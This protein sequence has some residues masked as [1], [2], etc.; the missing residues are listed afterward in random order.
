MIAVND[1]GSTATIAKVSVAPT[2]NDQVPEE[3]P[4]FTSTLKDVTTDEGKE[5]A[6]ALPFLGNPIPEVMWSRNGKPLEPSDR[7][8][9]TCDGRKVGIIINPADINDTG[10]YQCLLANPLGEIETKVNAHVR[11]VYQKPNFVSK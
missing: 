9:L 11:K 2:V 7:T 3:P 5:L 8:I 6:F 10:V 1:K 4:T